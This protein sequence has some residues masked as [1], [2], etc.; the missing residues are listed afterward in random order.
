MGHELHHS[1]G[2]HS[3]PRLGTRRADSQEL[4]FTPSPAAPLP[5]GAKGDQSYRVSLVHLNKPP[6]V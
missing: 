6:L 5:K 3:H 4:L 2:T 1:G